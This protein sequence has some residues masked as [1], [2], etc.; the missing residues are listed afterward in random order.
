M[1]PLSVS[2][3]LET[4]VQ[5]ALKGDVV[6]QIRF[7]TTDDAGRF[8][9][10]VASAGK[11]RVFARWG[12][13]SVDREFELTESGPNVELGDLVLRSGATLRGSVAGCPGGQAVA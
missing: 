13:A 9:V 5:E 10:V 12:S 8:T 11:Y 7:A 2:I 4:T 3:A 6:D 1:D